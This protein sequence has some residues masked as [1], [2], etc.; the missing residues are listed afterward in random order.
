MSSR[1]IDLDKVYSGRVDFAVYALP[2]QIKRAM[3]EL[4]VE[5]FAYVSFIH[6]LH[7][8][9]CANW[10]SSEKKK[11]LTLICWAISIHSTLNVCRFRFCA[12]VCRLC[13]CLRKVYIT[14]C[15][16][17][18]LCQWEEWVKNNNN[19]REHSN[20]RSIRLYWYSRKWINSQEN[21]SQLRNRKKIK[22][23]KTTV[24]FNTK[25]VMCVLQSFWVVHVN[26]QRHYQTKINLL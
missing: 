1:W 15:I 25:Y 21:R 19:N 22:Y 3:R 9:A 23:K 2:I 24:Y 18:D 13:V 8:V 16:F 17:Y 6:S 10:K 4:C 14:F 7:N 26:Q 11:P 5:V 20:L 12:N